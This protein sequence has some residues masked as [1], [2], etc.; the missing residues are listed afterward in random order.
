MPKAAAAATASKHRFE[1]YPE[2]THQISS[3][4]Q[5]IEKKQVI[6]STTQLHHY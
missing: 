5:D 3:A 2:K 4:C 6:V 1:T